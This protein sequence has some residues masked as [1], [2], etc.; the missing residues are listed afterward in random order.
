MQVRR[1]PEV[2]EAVE[3]LVDSRKCA[4]VSFFD[5]VRE[6]T[7][8]GK[9]IPPPID[10]L[11]DDE[12][13][14]MFENAG[15]DDFEEVVIRMH[16]MPLIVLH[17]YHNAPASWQLVLEMRMLTSPEMTEATS[18]YALFK[19]SKYSTLFAEYDST[20]GVAGAY[21]ELGQDTNAA[22]CLI[23][24]Y[25]RYYGYGKEKTFNIK[26]EP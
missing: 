4:A 5:V 8:D 9:P 26:F 19:L 25:V 17:F 3:R 6:E 1:L 12:I 23:S 13:I 22:A 16:G 7:I 15:D 10:D 21:M 2:V 14:R 18:Q 24:Y 20:Y 11:D